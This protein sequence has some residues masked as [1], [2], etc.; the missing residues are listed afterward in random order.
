MLRGGR[1]PRQEGRERRM[2]GARGLG[3]EADR[4]TGRWK[5]RD[6]AGETSHAQ[7]EGESEKEGAETGGGRG[8]TPEGRG[9]PSRQLLPVPP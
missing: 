7:G 6:G 3:W 8:G 2:D 1:R 9:P 4:R 5:G